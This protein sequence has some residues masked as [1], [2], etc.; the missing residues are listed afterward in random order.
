MS[1]VER[2]RAAT[3]PPE[4]VEVAPR[5][6]RWKRFAWMNLS[7]VG[8][9]LM[10]AV[11]YLVAVLYL[12][13]EFTVAS[14]AVTVLYAALLGFTIDALVVFPWGVRR[15]ALIPPWQFRVHETQ[16]ET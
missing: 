16:E 11:P 2:Y 5:R 3:T 10:A 4:G 13:V 1:L 12:G 9:I 6:E 7:T 14:A 15:F 8:S